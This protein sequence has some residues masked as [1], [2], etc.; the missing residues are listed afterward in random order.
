[1]EGVVGGVYR[2][3]FELVKLESPIA[4]PYFIAIQG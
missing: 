3:P 4:I 1:M 2:G